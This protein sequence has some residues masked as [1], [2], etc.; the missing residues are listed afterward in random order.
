MNQ[1]LNTVNSNTDYT[2][3]KSKEIRVQRVK[4]ISSQELYCTCT[5]NLIS[6]VIHKI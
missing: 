5:I 3:T 1:D 2:Q 4:L 6:D